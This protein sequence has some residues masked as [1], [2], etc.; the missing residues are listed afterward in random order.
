MVNSYYFYNDFD[1][2]YFLRAYSIYNDLDFI[3]FLSDYIQTFSYVIFIYKILLS[4][5][6]SFLNNTNFL[7]FSFC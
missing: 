3:Y 2:I 7:S 1:F 5:E 6:I 4:E